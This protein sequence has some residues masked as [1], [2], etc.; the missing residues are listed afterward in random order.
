[1]SDVHAIV[2]SLRARRFPRNR[3][4]EAHQSRASIEARRLHRF[5]RGVE[6]DLAAAERVTVARAP[7]GRFLVEMRF[8]SVRLTR[9]VLLT[10]D[11]LALLRET[12]GIA[13][14]LSS[15]QRMT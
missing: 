11:D 5:L 15:G 12:P 10:V 9:A 7:A 13:D 4:F 14:L 1:V 6:R 2:R 3:N 8:P